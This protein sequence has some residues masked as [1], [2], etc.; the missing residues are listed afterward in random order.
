MRGKRLFDSCPSFYATITSM[1][2]KS[3]ILRASL[4]LLLILAFAARQ[5]AAAA[6]C[7][8]PTV[9]TTPNEGTGA[10]TLFG[11]TALATDDV[12]AVGFYTVTTPSLALAEHW[13]GTSWQV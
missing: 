2:S 9:A 11:V 4:A 7:G 1:T 12:W 10:N 3:P 5:S 6:T 13:D 8:P